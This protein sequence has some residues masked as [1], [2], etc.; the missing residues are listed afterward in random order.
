MGNAIDPVH[1]LVTGDDTELC[2]TV[3]GGGPPVLVVGSAIYYPRTFSERI[4][5]SCRIAFCDLRHFARSNTSTR[6]NP[7]NL[8]SYISDIE[9]VR[10]VV[11]FE[12]F[13]LVGH[14][15][16]GNIAL[17]Y[18]KR[19]PNNVSQLVLI[20]TPPCDVKSTIEEGQRYWEA[21]ASGERREALRKRLSGLAGSDWTA[22]SVEEAF[23]SEYVANGPKYW[24]DTHFD[25]T[26]L[27]QGVPIDMEVM[28]EF[29]TFFDNYTFD[30]ATL[31]SLP[32]LAIMGRHDYVVPHTLW[33]KTA[34]FPN[35][36]YHLLEKSGHTPQLEEQA[37]FDP[38]FLAWLPGA[39]SVSGT[40]LK[41]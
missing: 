41:E 3:E 17:E 30:L 28:R 21:Q 27:W 1:G 36:T 24:Y 11:G 35:V 2:Y 16:H 23:V 18:A 34:S 33:D 7:V 14:S 32:V 22:M 8:D 15:H 12:R 31:E 5:S 19:Y 37:T 38:M 6:Q 39:K 4:R 9:R 29:K 26:R 40:K 25:A 10:A 20:G 13:A